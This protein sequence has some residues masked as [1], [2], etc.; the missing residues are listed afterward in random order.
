MKDGH[1]SVPLQVASRGTGGGS[2][3][4]SAQKSTPLQHGVA[5]GAGPASTGTPQKF[6]PSS[7]P[8]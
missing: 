1:K 8:K 3:G 2:A 4:G 6:T 7:G 5:R